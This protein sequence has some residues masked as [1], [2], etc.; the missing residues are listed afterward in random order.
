[1]TPAAAEA[2]L[3]RAHQP[4]FEAR[5]K[6]RVVSPFVRPLRAEL[7]SDFR[8]GAQA[9]AGA[10]ALLLVVACA[11]VASLMLARALARR[12]EIA[13][14]V[15]VGASRARLAV[16]L[17]AE[18][19]LLSL[20]GG[21]LGLLLGYAALRALVAAIP[22]EIPRWAAFSLDARVFAF[23]L[24]ASALTA[25]LFGWAPLVHALRGDV[26]QSMAG[27]AV[28]TTG[29]PRGGRTL[30]L[31]V[32]GEFALAALLLVC[33]GLL[34]SAFERVR[35]VDPGFDPSGVLTFGV[36]LPAASYPD[37]A[38]RLAFWD[39]LV[40]RMQALPGV[41]AASVI[42]CP[43]LGCHWGTF[44]EAEG[45]PPR[46]ASDKQP[47]VLHRY[48]SEGYFPTLGI[49]LRSGRLLEASDGRT[50]A[51]NV[52]VANEAF[53]RE[54]LPGED[55]PV[56]RRIRRSSSEDAPWLT[57]VGVVADVKH[58]G[59]ERPMRPGLY[60]PL[61]T[62]PADALTVALRTDG[63][64]ASLVGSARAAVRELDA[65]LALYRVRTMEQA[66]R[67]SLVARATYSWLL[68]VFAGLALL[69][70]LGGT[71][72]VTGY[73]AS[74]RSRE[75]G[76]RVAL[77][78]RAADIR[79]SVL[80]GSLAV[81]GSGMALGAGGSV[82][83]GRLLGNMLFGVSPHEPAVI[84]SA[85]GVLALAAFA[86]SWLPAARASRVDPMATL[87]SE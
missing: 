34:L 82:L 10:V 9:L 31:L 33:G 74:Q 84:A 37:A 39:R 35:R 1:V 61:A 26:R 71:Y 69:L 12:R 47:V 13:I 79:K 57:I 58:Y 15:A 45:E 43:P 44:F 56:G 21:A 29:A 65:D 16:Q 36:Y 50:G 28:G 62:H 19:L 81:V 60:F 14:R 52:V 2:E 23:A 46:G 27:V 51:S 4:I 87:R 32:G 20:L 7:V 72:G 48:A 76:I 5:D 77:G 30:R 53:V 3:L 11:N 59:L 24:G 17:L 63:D 85:L 6:E 42:T 70:A 68:A 25:V 18:S 83:A 80:K 54:F 22:D 66:L 49:R 41:S 8:A 67:R 64:P 86:A 73:L 78:A 40:D 75:L 55:H 38:R